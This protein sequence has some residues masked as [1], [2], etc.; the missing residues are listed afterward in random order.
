MT[1]TTYE[2]GTGRRKCAIAQVKLLKGSGE[3]VVNGKPYQDLFT[4]V[5]YQRT[6]EKPLVV[7]DTM[8]KYNIQVKVTGGMTSVA[9]LAGDLSPLVVCRGGR[10]RAGSPAARPR[11][12]SIVG[13]RIRNSFRTEENRLWQN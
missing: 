2:R 13:R 7:T 5:N 1:T 4:M 3:I 12:G 11:T 10:S 9:P 8:G 6:I